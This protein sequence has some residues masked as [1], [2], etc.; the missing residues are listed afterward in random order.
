MKYAYNGRTI[1]PVVEIYHDVIPFIAG[2]SERDFFLDAEKCAKAWKVA[3]EAIA[4]YF[5]DRLAPRA[6]MAGPFSYGHLV[7]IGATVNVPDEGEPNVKYFA[8]DIDEAIAI[9]KDSKGIDFADNDMARHYFAVNKYLQEEFPEY[10]ILP[11]AG[12]DHESIITTAELMRGQ[13]FFCDI[14]DEPEKV[15]EFLSLLT[16]SLIDFYHFKVKVNGGDSTSIYDDFA[17]IIPP[18]MWSEF[19]IPY[20]NRYYEGIGAKGRFLHCENVYPEQLRYLKDAKI[21]FYQ[22]SVSPRLTLENVRENTDIP[23]DWLLYAF[24]IVN[25]SDEQIQNWV[26]TAIQAGINTLRTQFGGYAWGAG[27]MDRIMAFLKAF[28]KYRVE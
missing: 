5:G 26:D 9:L 1:S 14:Y 13:D 7:S 15:H 6:P 8:S 18:H 19:V 2:I 21:D 23:F 28:D 12:Y 20:W 25:M 10:K 11:L 4:N 3:N 22:P 27:K 24:D 16:D 17:S